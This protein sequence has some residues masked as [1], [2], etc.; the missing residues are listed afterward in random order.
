MGL[1][2]FQPRF[3][4][5]ILSGEKTHTIRAP[6]IHMDRIGSIMHLYTG[7]RHKGAELLFRAPCIKVQTVVFWE[8]G[9]VMISP[10]APVRCSAL[11]KREWA[12]LRTSMHLQNENEFVFL[13]E[14]EREAF[15]KRDGFAGYRA[16]QKF[17]EGKL[18]WY[19]AIFHWSYKDRFTE[20]R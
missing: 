14:E 9:R 19:G 1:Y 12:A 2:N 18:P 3:V 11:S 5:R 16:M 20:P 15:A 10:F 13:D 8:D 17:W 7:L 4:A 6:R